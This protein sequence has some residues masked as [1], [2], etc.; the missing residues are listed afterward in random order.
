MPSGT[1]RPRPVSAIIG[2]RFQPGC[3]A[4]AFTGLVHAIA[5]ACS[6]RRDRGRLELSAI[7]S[8]FSPVATFVM[9]W[10]VPLRSSASQLMY[11]TAAM[12]RN[13]ASIGRRT[14]SALSPDDSS[15]FGRGAIV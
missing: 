6:R 10:P 14:R 4:P 11:G 12:G 1:R 9:T 5:V 3:T 7:T 2:G 13:A 15:G 8:T